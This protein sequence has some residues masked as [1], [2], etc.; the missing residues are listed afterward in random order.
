MINYHLIPEQGERAREIPAGG[1]VDRIIEVGG[2]STMPQSLRAV[3]A[4]GTISMI[5][6]LSGGIMNVPLG[7]IVTRHVRLQ[8]ITVGSGG[9]FA[10]MANAIAQHKLRP[11]VSRV[12]AFEEPRLALDYLSSGKHFGK[13]CIKH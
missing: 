2:Q 8:G 11:V 3:R 10:Q 5:G 12:F 4:G 1:G 9:D 6:V 7:Q 13:I